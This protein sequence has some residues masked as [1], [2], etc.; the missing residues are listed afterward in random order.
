MKVTR[1]CT[2]AVTQKAHTE[3]AEGRDGAETASTECTAHL[4]AEGEKEEANLAHVSES[5]LVAIGQN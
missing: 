3:G 1:I 4:D 2:R 5:F